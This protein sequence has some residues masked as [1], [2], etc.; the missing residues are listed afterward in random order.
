MSQDRIISLLKKPFIFDSQLSEITPALLLKIVEFRRDPREQEKE[1]WREDDPEA[2]DTLLVPAPRFDEW[3]YRQ[4]LEEGVRPLADREPYQVARILIDA[5]AS[6]IRLGMHQQDFDKGIEEDSSEVWCRKLNKPDRDY[7]DIRGIL[8]QT[9]TYACEQVYKKARESIDALDQALRNHR[10]VVFRRLR[11]YLYAT[12]PNDQTLPWIR[13]QI[14]GHE[15]FSRWEH[16]YEFQLM[17]RKA[18]EHF[19][20][21]LL[22]EEEKEEIFGNILSGP[23]MED[24]LEWA[25]D[26]YSNQAFQKR[27]RYFH[28]KQL[29][30]F[31]TLLNGELRDYFDE[32]EEDVHTDELTDDSYH[33]YNVGTGGIV[34]YKS[35]KSV[36]DLQSLTDEDLISYLNKWDQK[37]MVKDDWLLEINI[38]ALAKVFQ[39][40]FKLQ[41]VPNVER[42]TFWMQ[43]RDRIARPIYITAMLN[44]MTEFVKEKK[45]D[46][47]DQWIE[48]CEW[49]LSHPDSE[50]VEGQPRPEEGSRDHPDWSRSRRAVVDFIDSCLS[51]DNEAPVAAKDGLAMLLQQVC[52]QPDWRL[53]NNRP[54][55]LSQDRPITEAINN[56]R[57]RALDSLVNFAF[58][59]RRALPEDDL[60]EVI[61]ILNLRIANN[62]VIPLTRPEYAILGMHFGN[63]CHL[64]ENWAAKNRDGFFP[65]GKEIVWWDAFGSYLRFNEPAMPAFEILRDDFKYAIDNLQTLPGQNGN[66]KKI[67]NRL[68]QHLFTYFLWDVYPLSGDDESLL[69]NF[70]AK[71]NDDRAQWADLF[72]Y[73]GR[74]L[75]ISDQNLEQGLIDRII[76][77]FD[78]RLQVAEPMELNEFTYWLEAECLDPEW[79]L[80]SFLKILDLVQ[81]RGGSIYLQVKILTKFLPDHLELIVECF[82][83]ITASINHET[84]IHIPTDEAKTIL[85]AG[86]KSENTK[87]KENAE[88]A[89]E[90]LLRSRK[91]EFMDI[92]H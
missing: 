30:P 4:I 52:T 42:L 25:G 32:L 13:E 73:V 69:E 76:I 41:I 81:Q 55:L 65:R 20:P 24:Y 47:L 44:T 43:N 45:F 21:R 53:D 28:H 84:Q 23:S 1:T 66:G 3:E 34:R 16:H 72:D 6:M 56:T 12:H 77:F 9:L 29:R 48:C 70:Y 80:Q 40:L 63:L 64:E 49:V 18:S 50:Q 89:R 38:D 74:S 35:P 87:I 68:G 54:V 86:L 27:K 17:I 5:V 59:I 57:S 61:S 51:K 58:W 91:F 2:W 19:G 8:V 78:W 92:D 62:S 67:V 79:R 85:K 26:R 7:Q 88:R 75:K 31:A 71:T 33:L 46:H 90:N 14:L 10:W 39:S 11:Q 15:D 36:E 60:S 83:K 82:A 22:S 37:H